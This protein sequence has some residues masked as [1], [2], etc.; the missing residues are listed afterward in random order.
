MDEPHDT[1]LDPCY[2]HDFKYGISGVEEVE[3]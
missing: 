2:A 1:P 3:N